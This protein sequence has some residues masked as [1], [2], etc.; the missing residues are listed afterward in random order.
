MSLVACSIIKRYN[1][2]FMSK[3]VFAMFFH[4]G[5]Q[6]IEVELSN[7][8]RT[9]LFLLLLKCLL[10]VH[11]AIIYCSSLLATHCQSQVH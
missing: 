4:C 7:F 6:G 10:L 11:V 1:G 9:I 5:L 2:L 3:G 8:Y